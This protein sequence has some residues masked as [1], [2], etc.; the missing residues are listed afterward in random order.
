MS[1]SVQDLEL[2]REFARYHFVNRCWERYGICLS[3]EEHKQIME[4][5][6]HN[7]RAGNIT[8]FYTRDLDKN[9]KL[10]QVNIGDVS[11]YVIYDLTLNELTTSLPEN[12]KEIRYYA[13]GTSIF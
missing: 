6:R 3:G 13:V 8:A 2:H 10:Y 4:A 9:T 1:N 5:I 12:P 11:M 7:Q